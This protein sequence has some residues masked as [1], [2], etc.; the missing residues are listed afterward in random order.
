[1]A[2]HSYMFRVRSLLTAVLGLWY[3]AHAV[4][5]DID[6]VSYLKPQVNA[7][8]YT[9]A[10][11]WANHKH[12]PNWE[13]V[14]RAAGDTWDELPQAYNASFKNPCWYNKSG[15]VKCL[16]YFQILGVSKCGTTDLYHRLSKHPQMFESLNKGPH[17]WDE[18]SW[19]LRG[20]CTAPPKGDFDGY[21]SLYARAA[22]AFAGGE[23]QGITGEASSNTYTA[24]NK[25]YLRGP[26]W[27]RADL[28][29][30]MPDLMWESSPWLRNIIIFRDPVDRYYSAFYYYRW[31]KKDEPTPGPQEFHDT[32][33][34]EIKEWTD[35]VAA[36]GQPH[37]VRHYHPQQLVKGMYAEFLSDW[38]RVWPKEQLLILRNEDYKVAQREHMEVVFNFLGLRALSEPE[39]A[40]VMTMP[41]RNKNSDKYAPMWAETRKILDDFYAPFNARLAKMMAD[42]RYLWPKKPATPAAT[43]A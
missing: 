37:C 38:L 34:S 21:V 16:P 25:V 42:D 7:P 19:P 24:A 22:A 14:R 5:P 18:C 12:L 40:K 6:P 27:D 17:W 28:Q 29:V 31:W 35:C 39:W 9:V 4:V 2:Q 20:A 13:E 3:C 43:A 32:V 11:L 1:M 30:S 36:H 23:P 26:A 33:V 15:Q 8:T 10:E 41:A